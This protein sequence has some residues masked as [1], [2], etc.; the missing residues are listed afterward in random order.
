MARHNGKNGKVKVG[1]GA[2]TAVLAVRRWNVRENLATDDLTAMGDDWQSHATG[3]PGW[4]GTMDVVLDRTDAGGQG[5]LT[6]GASVELKLYSDGDGAGKTYFAG[7][8]SITD[9]GVDTNFQG[10]VIKNVG[11]TG[12]GA[13]TENLVGG[14]P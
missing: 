2:G 3:I 10:A 6:I 8:A 13:L 14:G 7:T 1:S 12:N 9:I 4:T 5:V 11:F